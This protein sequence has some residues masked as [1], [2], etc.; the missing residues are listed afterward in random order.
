MRRDPEELK[1]EE[2]DLPSDNS[3]SAGTNG[4]G[5]DLNAMLNGDGEAMTT[6]ERGG[7]VDRTEEVPAGT[8]D[9]PDR[10]GECDEVPVGVAPET[11]R[12]LNELL[13]EDWTPG[14]RI[15]KLKK[16]REHTIRLCEADDDAE[17]DDV[18]AGASR[19]T[20]NELLD[21]ELGRDASDQEPDTEPQKV[22]KLGSLPKPAPA[23]E[24]E[25]P[26]D[27]AGYRS[28]VEAVREGLNHSPAEVKELYKEYEDAITAIDDG[29]EGLAHY[30]RDVAGIRFNAD[31]DLANP[32]GPGST[33]F[34]EVGHFLDDWAGNGQTW[35]SDSE[36]YREA[37]RR[38]VEGRVALYMERDSCTR[39][40][41]FA[42]LSQELEGHDR[43]FVS[44]I[45]GS[46]TGCRCQGDYGHDPE[47]WEREGNIE[48]EA[49]AN[50]FAS[51]MT[52]EKT[53]IMREYFPNAYEEFLRLIRRR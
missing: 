23:P 52:D 40:E 2:G 37:I 21:G 35:L 14:N 16:L 8:A 3:T 45:S 50:M 17:S 20:L 53:K 24:F 26:G 6:D 34:H 27:Q 25:E 10:A 33:Y 13:N 7:N 19:G 30:D 42:T 11:R 47:Y 9:A 5:L 39:E 1:D 48:K 32:I 28:I 18:E 15:E 49:F 22:L 12:S 46:V 4:T 41:A 36:A 29:Y 31:E 38:D 51:S 43:A 44:D